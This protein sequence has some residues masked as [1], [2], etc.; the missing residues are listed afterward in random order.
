[1][2][3]STNDF[4]CYK[5]RVMTRAAHKP[6]SYSA[7]SGT[8]SISCEITSG[9]VTMAATI[10]AP[11]TAYGRLFCNFST[12]NAPGGTSSTTAT[13]T[14]N[15]IPNATHKVNTKLRYWLMSVVICTFSGAL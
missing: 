4:V 9:G 8:A 7:T 10:K 5:R 14:S 3:N 11:T 13:G 1:M 6:A 2:P 15:A 12:V